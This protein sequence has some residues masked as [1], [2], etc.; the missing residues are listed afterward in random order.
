MNLCDELELLSLFVSCTVPTR[1]SVDWCFPFGQLTQKLCNA[2]VSVQ[3]L[4]AA[5]DLIP[6]EVRG[7]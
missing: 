3:T 1:I 6:T 7:K 5:L 4:R 2:F